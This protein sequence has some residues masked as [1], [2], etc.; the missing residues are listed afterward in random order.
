MASLIEEK[1]NSGANSPEDFIRTS[2]RKLP[3]GECYINERWFES[4]KASIIVSRKHPDGKITCGFYLVDLYCLGVKDSFYLHAIRESEFENVLDEMSEKEGLLEV[5]YVLVHNIIYGA[6]DFAGGYDFMV[7]KSF[8]LTSFLLEDDTENIEF[9]EV[10][11]GIE[12]KPGVIV[13]DAD[14]QKDIIKLLKKN[15]GEGN[16]L[17]IEEKDFIPQ[18]D[19]FDYEYSGAGN[20]DGKS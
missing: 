19:G 5:D 3:L 11:F 6:V 9:I 15:A 1:E 20:L 14:P 18:S 7:H 8:E 17:V 10:P 16:Y 4:G 13:S 2:A 12:G